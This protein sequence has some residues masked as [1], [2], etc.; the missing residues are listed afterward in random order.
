VKKIK[1]FVFI[2]LLFA[3]SSLNSNVYAQSS[4]ASTNINL[5]ITYENNS[6]DSNVEKFVTNSGG[7]VIS[8]MSELGAIEVK[9]SP[10]LIPTIQGYSSVES[11]SPDHIIKLQ[12]AKQVYFN[13]YSRVNTKKADLFNQYQWDIK[14]VTNNGKS[15]NLQA[16]NHNVVVGI[17]DTGVDEE[18]PDL[19]ANLLGGEN[20]VP[21]NFENDSTETGNPSDIEDRVGHGTHVA[22]TIAGNG[23]IMGVAPNIGFKSYRVFDAAGDTSSSIISSAII[24][25]TKDKVKVINLSIDGYDL[26][27]KCYWTD[28]STGTVYD[29]GNDMSDYSLYKKAIKYA[30]KHGVTVVTAAGNASLDC[31][32]GKNITDYLNGEYGSQGFKYVGVGIEVP[33]EIKGVINVSATSENNTLASYS[34]YG[35]GVIDIAA[36]GGDLNITNNSIGVSTMCF[37]T[38]LNNSYTYMDGTSMAAPKV[39]ATAAL[40]ISKHGTIGPENVANRLYKSADSLNTKDS[41]EY[42]G[43][44]LVNSYNAVKN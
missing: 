3:I 1:G 34:N 21:E 6:I 17:I 10:S 14:E 32:N 11:I 26:K 37:S 19:K 7:Q 2:L 20:F 42:F 9:C 24:Q 28:P 12:Q 33:G 16:G 18:H 29:L 8:E 44:G 36:P 39:S 41:Y 15:F 23:R 5:I 4:T 35:K 40:I 30:V 31:S 13:D 43:H 38:Y 27:G 25:A 22:G